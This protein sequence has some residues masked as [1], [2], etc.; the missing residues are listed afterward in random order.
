MNKITSILVKELRDRTGMGIM[1]CKQFLTDACGDIELAIDNMRKSGQIKVAKKSLRIVKEG[2]IITNVNK[3]YTYGVNIEL[4]CE[5]DFFAKSQEFNKF[6][7]QISNYAIKNRITSIEHILSKF[8]N[9]L[10][11]LIAKVGENI[12]ISRFNVLEGENI[13]FYMHGT[14]IGVLLSISAKIYNKRIIKNISMHIAAM[15]PEFINKDSIPEDL[16]A[17]ERKLQIDMISKTYKTKEILKKIINE[18]M[19]KF[20]VNLSLVNQYFIMNSSKTVGQILKENNIHINN[21][22]RFEIGEKL[23]NNFR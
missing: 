12:Q 9:K 6:G 23:K 17:H 4:N 20:I 2:I 16:L 11:L 13:S 14:R 18:R 7:Q 15:N 19:K 8:N 21:F 1:E 5:T 22:I 3:N 10:K